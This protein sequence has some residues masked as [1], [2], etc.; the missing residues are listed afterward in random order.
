MYKDNELEEEEEREEGK[1][2]DK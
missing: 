2:A 1:T